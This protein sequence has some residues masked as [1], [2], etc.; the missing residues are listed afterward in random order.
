MNLRKRIRQLFLAPKP[1]YSTSETASLLGL[2]LTAVEEAIRAGELDA[3]RTCSGYSL[4]WQEVAIAVTT[5]HPRETIEKALGRQT[6]SV[7]PDLLRLA[8]LRVRLP[9]CQTL[10]LE[11]REHTTVDDVLARHLLDL[12]AAEREW[13]TATSPQVEAAIRWPES[14]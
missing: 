3:T 10:M 12:A 1:V 7:L 2:K 5:Q 4:S 14:P 9:R 13:L 11:Q 8:E 6:S